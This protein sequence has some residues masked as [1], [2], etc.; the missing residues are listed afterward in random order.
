M[1][2]YFRITWLHIAVFLA[3]LAALN[4]PLFFLV[5]EQFA[6]SGIA[7]ALGALWALALDE[8]ETHNA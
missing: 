1:E 4:V 6:I 5:G 7:D 8:K 3:V 2:I